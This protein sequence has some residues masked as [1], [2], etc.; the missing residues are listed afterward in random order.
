MLYAELLRGENIILT[1]ITKADAAAIAKW[2]EDGEYLRL[3]D[4]GPAV[5]LNEDQVLEWISEI[6]K[7]KNN[8]A[9]GLRRKSDNALV[10]VAELDEVNFQH[11]NS[12]L[13][14]GLGKPYWDMGLGSEAMELIV[15]YAFQEL[16]L[17][18]LQLTVFD[19]NQR[20]QAVYRKVGFVEEGRLREWIL[21]D[22]QRYDMLWM[23][24]LARDWRAMHPGS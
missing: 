1:A 24:L 3:L 19:Y 8:Y 15:R 23:G 17:H 20:A 22:G 4:T 16:N 10:G 11:G 9:F 5:P 6:P 21:R 13:S 7:R 18:R 12:G 2:T 14:I